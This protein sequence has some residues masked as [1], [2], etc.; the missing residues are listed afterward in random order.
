MGALPK[1]KLSPARKPVAPET[2]K[3]DQYGRDPESPV[4]RLR[5]QS[6]YD[7]QT[8]YFPFYHAEMAALPRL[9]VCYA[10]VLTV[11]RLSIGRPRAHVKDPHHAW[12]LPISTA[13]LAEYCRCNVRDVQRQISEM[14]SRGMIAVKTVKNGTVKYAVSLLY[15]KWRE[16]DDYA[17]WK[18]RQ[19]VDIDDHIEESESDDA[20]Q[21]PI[22]KEAVALFKKPAAVRPGRASR[23]AKVSVGIRDV[24]CQNDS[25]AVDLIF[26]PVVQS[27][28][29]VITATCANSE[30]KA[31]GEEKGN[32][33]RHT[34]RDIPPN[35]K[36]DTQHFDSAVRR[37]YFRNLLWNRR[38]VSNGT[39]SGRMP[40]RAHGH[41]GWIVGAWRMSRHWALQI[42][43]CDVKNNRFVY[44]GGAAFR[45]KRERDTSL[46]SIPVAP[47]DTNFLLDI[48]SPRG[49]ENNLFLEPATVESLM[50]VPVVALLE[51]AAREEDAREQE[52]KS[53][54]VGLWERGE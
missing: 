15:P 8:G 35:E 23:A 20:E 43:Y 50:Q 48:E 37:R 3:L 34:R 29:L 16:L 9:A 31:K 10:L 38:G 25:K 27:G 19:V 1:P 24:V 30:S 26:N 53:G 14:E 22:S 13:E 33:E 18:R 2:R 5:A 6:N 36:T 4:E 51:K 40:L 12:T 11:K 46:A 7:A 44:L 28:R 49:I 41:R 17:V 21:L 32:A 52:Q 54:H 45:T 47:A 39:P 42:N